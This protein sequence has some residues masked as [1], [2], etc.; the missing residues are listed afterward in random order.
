MDTNAE[1]LSEPAVRHALNQWSRPGWF[2]LK[3]LG[4]QIQIEDV[5]SCSS[6]ALTWQTEYERRSVWGG[7]EPYYGGMVD[8]TGVPPDAWE[9]EIAP[10]AGFQ[11]PEVVMRALPPWRRGRRLRC[12]P[13]RRPPGGHPTTASSG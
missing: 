13:A 12:W 9:I 6:D 3:Q 5:L 8:D 7:M 4:D 11:C 2:R 10:P 1:R